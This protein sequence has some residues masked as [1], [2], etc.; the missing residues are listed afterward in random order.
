MNKVKASL[1]L[2]WL[3]A[4]G[5]IAF[6]IWRGYQAALA[7]RGLD[8]YQLGSRSIAIDYRGAQRRLWLPLLD[9]GAALALTAA[10]LTPRMNQ[11]RLRALL[12]LCLLL[13][14]VRWSLA[15]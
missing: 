15:W 6:V 3:L 2:R 9:V 14:V 12:A 7:W 5:L 10:L 1:V 4:A 11:Q 13:C 8:D